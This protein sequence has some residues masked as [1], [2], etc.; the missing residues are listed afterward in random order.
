MTPYQYGA[1]NPVLFIDVNGDSI[2]VSRLSKD[3]LKIYNSNI[4]LLSKSKLFSAYYKV[5]NESKTVYKISAQKGEEGTPTAAGQFFN[6]SNN[7]VGLGENI[8]AYVTVQELFH[9]F[10]SDG[11]FYKDD[12]PT[13][14]SSIETEG[15]IATFYV[16]D[17]ANLGYPQY[18]DW[19]KDFQND[20]WK[21]GI[22]TLG[23][24]Q[25]NEYQQ[26][27]QKAVDAR[28]VYYKKTG[29]NVPTYTSPNRGIKPKA[30][31][32]SIKLIK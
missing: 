7:E 13:P 6:P 2:D 31:E 26:M 24:V 12:K 14:L 15:D 3:Q 4:E 32:G 1:D 21:S 10:Q 23:K 8:N 22:P 16:M 18:G 17:E 19:S 28:I 20:S 27:F 30:L 5:L 9:A 11:A 25:S 29:M